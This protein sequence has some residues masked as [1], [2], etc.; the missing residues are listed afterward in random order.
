MFNS[1]SIIYKILQEG[2]DISFA[3]PSKP[4]VEPGKQPGVQD[5]NIIEK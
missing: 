2:P 3:S 1:D 4:I 5:P